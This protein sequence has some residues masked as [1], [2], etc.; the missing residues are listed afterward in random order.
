MGNQH[1][2]LACVVL[3]KRNY[4]SPRKVDVIEGF[5][6]RR[7]DVAIFVRIFVRAQEEYKFVNYL[8]LVCA[9]AVEKQV[10]LILIDADFAIQIA[11]RNVLESVADCDV[12]K[13]V[14]AE[15][16]EQRVVHQVKKQ[17]LVCLPQEPVFDHDGARRQGR[18]GRVEAGGGQIHRGVPLVVFCEVAELKHEHSVQSF[19]CADQSEIV[20]SICEGYREDHESSWNELGQFWLGQRTPLEPQ[21][22]CV[23]VSVQEAVDVEVVLVLALESQKI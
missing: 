20:L 19:E 3:E 9:D 17:S 10:V 18:Q 7:V 5:K 13:D 11:N 6:L 23:L 14:E 4:L 16:V 15:L 8:S 21:V 1:R 12:P 22:D 2:V